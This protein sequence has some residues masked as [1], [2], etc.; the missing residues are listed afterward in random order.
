MG[1]AGPVGGARGRGPVGRTG[2]WAVGGAE[3]SLRAGPGRRSL[4]GGP[5]SPPLLSMQ[6]PWTVFTLVFTVLKGGSDFESGAGV[7]RE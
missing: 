6:G 7:G 5:S 3:R 2:M 4:G 1:E